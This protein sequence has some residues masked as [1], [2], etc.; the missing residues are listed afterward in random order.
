MKGADGLLTNLFPNCSL[1]EQCLAQIFLDYHIL[2]RQDIK[3]Y[4]FP[5][6]FLLDLFTVLFAEFNNSND[7]IFC[8]K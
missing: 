1:S 5:G 3:Q 4:Y 7:S 2:R 8:R 6:Y